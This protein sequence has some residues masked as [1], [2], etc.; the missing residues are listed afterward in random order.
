M[1]IEKGGGRTR[2]PRSKSIAL[3]KK[4][5]NEGDKEQEAESDLTKEG[6]R[7]IGRERE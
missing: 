5:D 7:G 2:R 1:D 3:G 4:R 6:K